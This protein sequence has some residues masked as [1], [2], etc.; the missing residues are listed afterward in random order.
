MN[1]TP[2]R[3]ADPGGPVASHRTTAPTEIPGRKAVL[4]PHRT[5]DSATG[6]LYRDS[7]EGVTD[8]PGTVPTFQ[9]GIYR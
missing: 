9:G 2:A 4:D 5:L 7:G 6:T 1:A 8:L 3:L